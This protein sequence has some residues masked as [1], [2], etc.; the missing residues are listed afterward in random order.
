MYCVPRL[1]VVEAVSGT[2]GVSELSREERGW[3]EGGF[4]NGEARAEGGEGADDDMFRSLVTRWT[5]RA[6]RD[7]AGTTDVEL[8]IRYRFANPMYQLAVGKVG[9]EVAGMMIGAFERRAREVLG[10]R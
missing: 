5:V 1:G 4:A 8:R 6:G 10:R 2:E 7:A 3:V 9:E